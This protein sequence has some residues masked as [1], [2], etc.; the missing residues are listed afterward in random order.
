MT[1]YLTQQL[2]ISLA[3]A[4]FVMACFGIGAVCGSLLGGWLTD[5]AGFYPVQIFTLMGG[6]VMFI[7]LGFMRSYPLI[8]IFTFLLSLINE[9]FR[10]ANQTALA[11]YSNAANR[12]RSFT[13]NRL[14][15]NLGWAL[16]SGLGGF[17][18]D[19]NYSLLFWVDGCTNIAAALLLLVLLPWNRQVAAGKEA[20]ARQTEKAASPWN[21]R[22][23]L[24][25]TGLTVL[26]AL[27]F[28]QLMSTQPVF[29]K[30]QWHLTGREVGLVMALNGLLIAIFE[31]PLI[32]RYEG[33]VNNLHITAV[34][35]CL[36]GLSF[37]LLNV[38]PAGIAVALISSVVM[39]AGE[40]LSMPF[41]NAYWTG[42][43]VH[44]N[45]G[46]YAALYTLAYSVAHVAGPWAGSQL[47]GRAGFAVLWWTLGGLLFATAA[48]YVWLSGQS[49]TPALRS[50]FFKRKKEIEFKES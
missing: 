12:T 47:A 14:A 17:L 37:L 1:M 34:G 18:S 24:I 5:K 25:F 2:G 48:G 36:T 20:A 19:F 7:L 16:G 31:M 4:G 39:T 50:R 10:P 28:F 45:R 42:R 33:R 27:C 41:M 6:G 21:D 43:S 35:V 3:G 9:A 29:Y 40:M 46:Q 22:P 15:I 13:L 44:S 8:C 30:T 23:Y 38:L 49:G 11:F 32:L 26:F